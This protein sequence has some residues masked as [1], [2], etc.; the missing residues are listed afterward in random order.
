M[1]KYI[2]IFQMS[3]SQQKCSF[4]GLNKEKRK[5]KLKLNT[6]IRDMKAEFIEQKNQCAG[7]LP[8]LSVFLLYILI[9][10]NFFFTLRSNFS[11]FY[12]IFKLTNLLTQIVKHSFFSHSLFLIHNTIN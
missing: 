6:E 4:F 7:F 1:R 3:Q 5:K 2:F 12:S 8:L 9:K 11:F 10:L